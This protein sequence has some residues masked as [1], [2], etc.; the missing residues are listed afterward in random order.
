MP[1]VR[2]KIDDDEWEDVS[3]VTR[4]IHRSA[5]M[6]RLADSPATP[7]TIAEDTESAIASISNELSNLRDAGL[8]E[9]LVDE[10]TR[11]GRFYGLTDH[12]EHIAEFVKEVDSA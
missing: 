12:G 10:E 9:L 2:S 8:I 5:I 7:S 11:K 3:H 4:S 1:T 6:R